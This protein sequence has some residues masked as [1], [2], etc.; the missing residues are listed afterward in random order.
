MSAPQ[1]TSERPPQSALGRSWFKALVLALM[2]IIGG[3]SGLGAGRASAAV[4]LSLLLF[5]AVA[6]RFD[7]SFLLLGMFLPIYA[8]EP[9]PPVAFF[10]VRLLLIGAI[11]STDILARRLHLYRMPNWRWGFYGLMLLLASLVHSTES[12]AYLATTFIGAALLGTRIA[13]SPKFYRL[14]FKGYR[15]GVFM[16]SL[17]LLLEAASLI[18]LSPVEQLTGFAG[19]SYRSTAFSYQ[20]ALALVLWFC[21]LAQRQLRGR[22][23]CW[24]IE[25]LVVSAALLA[26][27]G[28]GGLLALVAAVII[29][30][31]S[32]GQVKTT[33]RFTAVCSIGVG[34][35]VLSGLSTLSV[36]RL[37]ES[38]R[39]PRLAVADQYGSGRLDLYRVGLG[40]AREHWEIG[41]GFEAASLTSSDLRTT[42]SSGGA[43]SSALAQRSGHLLILALLI[44]G[45][46][47]L[48][49]AGLLVLIDAARRAYRLPTRAA[50]SSWWLG[51][52]IMIYLVN[53]L[54]EA[55]GG[56]LGLENV[57]L[58]S[59]LVRLAGL[60]ISE[61]RRV[62]ANGAPMNHAD[63][64]AAA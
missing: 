61:R 20:A 37:F 54:F 12:G 43:A 59:C 19:F 58:F 46:V 53:S 9:V 26:S 36:D 32:T 18:D 30:P 42:Q 22:I 29:L 39:D 34:A 11:V 10:V 64:H 57:L 55:S 5:A 40:L 14:M 38:T 21:G 44:A 52:G 23:V 56:L 49:A 24:V 2:F 25:G 7:T 48:A 16:S 31:L 27:G 41:S 8:V 33:L 35:V 28:R 63:R 17:A 50:R 1:F 62:V 47:V 3:L 13:E 51:A 4:A 15:F 6:M 45:G 60:S